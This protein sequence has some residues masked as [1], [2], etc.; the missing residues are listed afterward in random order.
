MKGGLLHYNMPSF[1]GKK[2]VKRYAAGAFGHRQ[3]LD[4]DIFP[5][6]FVLTR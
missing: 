6:I 3:K 5:Y 2:A 4:L 1:S